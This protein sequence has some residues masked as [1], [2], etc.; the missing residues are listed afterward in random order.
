[1]KLSKVMDYAFPTSLT[2]KEYNHG[3]GCFVVKLGYYTD[4][5]YI[6]LFAKGF[7]E[8]RIKEAFALYDSLVCAVEHVYS[9]AKNPHFRK[10]LA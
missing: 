2:A 9:D 6:P 7:D 5:M 3:K 8:E 4:T 1:M 10:Q